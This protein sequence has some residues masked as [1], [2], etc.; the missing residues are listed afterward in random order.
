[1]LKKTY[2]RLIRC[3]MVLLLI[4]L[5]SSPVAR[6][7]EPDLQQR[8]TVTYHEVPLEKVLQDITGTT[9]IHFSYSVELIP[10]D[11][12]ITCNAVNKPLL[13]VLAEIFRQ[14]GIRYEVV[15]G[16]LVLTALPGETT[17][18]SAG[19]P[20]RFTISGTI[21]DSATHELL[22][23]AAVYDPSTRAGIISNNYGFY[24]IT[25][26][27]GSYAMQSSFL[28][29]AA[30][31]RSLDLTADV[32]WNIQLKQAP[33]RMKEII[34][35]SVAQENRALNLMT[36]Q[37]NVDP[38]TVK[39]QSAALGETDMLKSLDNLPG[40]TFQ[41]EGSS[42]FSVRGGN[43][44]QNLILIDEAPL[45]N[46]SHLLG[47]FT[48]IIPEAIKHTEVYR[49]DFPVQYG[50]RLS[51][52]I[53]IRA[54][55]GNM[56][57]FS[58]SASLGPVST[59]FSVEG[60]LKKDA[61]SYFVSFRVSTFGLLVKAANPTVEKFRFSDFTTKFNLKM[62][63]RDR[64]YLTLFSGRDIF[65]NKPGTERNGL[66][67]G[68]T[69]ATLRWSH[70]YGTRLFSNT[71]LYGSRYDYSLYTNYDKKLAWNSDIK[72]TNLKTEFTWYITPNNTARFGINAGGYFFNPGNYNAPNSALDTMRVSRVNSSEIVA[73][74]GDE[75]KLFSLIR[76][77][78]G[79]R[80]SN[81]S[82][83][84]EA[85][86]IIY[87][88]QYVPVSVNT[89]AKGVRYYSSSFA[90]P[91]LSLSVKTGRNASLKAS[92]NR[93]IQHIN[94][95]NNSISPFNSLDV[96][97]PSG[98]NIKPQLADIYDIGF[99]SFWSKRSVELSMDVYY[100][101]MYNQIGYQNHAEMFLNPYLEGELR[102]GNGLA[103]GFEIMLRKIQG[104]LT[105]QISYG[106]VSSTLQIAGL[107]GGKEYPSHQDRPVD[108]SFTVDYNLT[109]RWSMNLNMIYTSGMPLSTPTGFY[110]YRGSQIPVY[111][112]QNNDRLPDYKRL[113]LGTVWRLNKVERSFEHY[114]SF[115]VYNFF[116][117]RNYA[118][119][120]FN[121]IQGEDGK[122]YVPADKFNPQ[123][124]VITYRYIYSLV[125]SFTYSL[126]F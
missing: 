16:Y 82:D 71:T 10:A 73:F 17:T 30:E 60:P 114:L 120:N 125:P 40:I 97:L 111:A 56:K 84:G 41:S 86:S 106:Y 38:A 37:T 79:V 7:Q 80:L 9:H 23:G 122:Y 89:Y 24:S 115:T 48:P 35:N 108:F 36:A 18:V 100:K 51:S 27:A 59:R 53:D 49:A 94:Q 20:A 43:H 61:S 22:I 15:D 2:H 58:G 105:G 116:S 14:A 19:K 83:Y 50:G 85:F 87:N 78:Y 5:I 46:P 118:F 26:P 31:V 90:E 12:K 117:T 74:A 63:K 109:S 99:I 44:D 6:G 67:W 124:Q 98:P 42:Y 62:G 47:L 4:V 121:K 3:G 55:D 66:S 8:I 93:N 110:Y 88:D 104:R 75:M 11:K 34:I 95:I 45:Y 28:G 69:A 13:K 72:S 65:I 103:R 52:V 54:R 25:L 92:F 126:K 113:D 32:T 76:L 21:S 112:K 96:W 101:K 1:M 70:V 68:N 64:L 77:N 33:M 102:Q 91:R 119:L 39:R 57:R 123:Q 29:Y 107:N 81:W